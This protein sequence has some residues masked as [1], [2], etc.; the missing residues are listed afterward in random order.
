MAD[1]DD[2]RGYG[3][4]SGRYAE[5]GHF[6]R[7]R[8]RDRGRHRDTGIFDRDHDRDRARGAWGRDD[9]HR[10]SR[11]DHDE[12]RGFFERA[13]AQVRSWFDD[14]EDGRDRERGRMHERSG[15]FRGDPVHYRGG[16]RP[17]RGEERGAA[18]RMTR[19]QDR[20]RG[21]GGGERQP[22]GSD[23]DHERGD[24]GREY[25][26]GRY[27]SG[28]GAVGGNRGYRGGDEPDRGGR[29][30]MGYGGGAGTGTAAGYGASRAFGGDHP[31]DSHYE[32]W[33]RQQLAALDRDYHDYRTESR[34][35]F[36]SEFGQWRNR[37]QQQRQHLGKVNEHMDVVGSDGTH[38]GTV[39]KVQGDRIILTKNDPAA[40]GHHHSIPCSW[41]EEVAD[42]VKVNKTAEEAKRQWRDE[43]NRRA[44]F[45]PEENRRD[46][47]PHM[48]DR[49]FSGTYDRS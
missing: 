14:D 29:E 35:Q 24:F 22:W 26:T 34:Q 36:H 8:D 49:S 12:D 27:G 30:G 33:R 4:P 5:R 47:G 40:G 19:D 15:S 17:D 43:E 31:H 48:L 13:G 21:H 11:R 25:S 32:E 3:D 20:Y 18:G 10:G 1:R 38:I 39:D 37:R 2:Y 6:D 23:R 45:E 41:I 46:E 16:A 42:T 28:G 9:D 44:L 7:D